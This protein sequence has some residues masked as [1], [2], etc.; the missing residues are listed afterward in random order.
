VG[1]AEQVAIDVRIVCAT[2]RNLQQDV[3]E[4][5]FRAD[6][7]Y[8]LDVV[9]IAVPPLRERPED[10]PLLAGH[11]LERFAKG[12]AITGMEPDVLEALPLYPWPGNVRQL[13]N[14][15]ERACALAPG[16]EIRLQ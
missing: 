8:R 4:G 16:P 10:V 3:A 9:R 6:L 2:N 14:V 12:S 7:F 15:L 1:S 11:F 5:R 13:R